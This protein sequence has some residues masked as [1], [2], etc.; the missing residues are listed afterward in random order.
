MTDDEAKR[1][2]TDIRAGRHVSLE[3]G[4]DALDHALLA[5]DDRAKIVRT[6]FEEFC[7]NPDELEQHETWIDLRDARRHM[8]GAS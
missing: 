3:P 4:N 7:A 5:I 8:R 2:L 6:L 1:V